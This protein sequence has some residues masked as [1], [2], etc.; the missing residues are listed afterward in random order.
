[1]KTRIKVT[2]PPK[3]KFFCSYVNIYLLKKSNFIYAKI[4][5]LH[6]ESYVTNFMWNS[7]VDQS[8]SP[9]SGVAKEESHPKTKEMSEW[10]VLDISGITKTTKSDRVIKILKEAKIDAC[11]V[12]EI[13]QNES[14]NK[15]CISMTVRRAHYE[16]E[17]KSPDWPG[18]WI[19]EEDY[20]ATPEVGDLL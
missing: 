1:M 7:Y 2:D 10:V 3:A 4:A 15:A 19:I 14:R 11:K 5:L 16:D 18:S 12:T 9:T 6:I 20:G 8:R 17:S 13:Y